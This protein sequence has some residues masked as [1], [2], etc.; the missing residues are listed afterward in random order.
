MSTQ[1]LEQ[2]ETVEIQ[3]LMRRIAAL[4]GSALHRIDAL[5]EEIMEELEE[6][7][8]IADIEARKNEGPNIPHNVVKA[9]YE[10]KHGPLY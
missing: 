9:E 1:T 6:A 3:P 10:A 4:P 8:D 2:F 7:E 5:V